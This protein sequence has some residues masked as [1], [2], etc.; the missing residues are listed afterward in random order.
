MGDPRTR[1]YLIPSRR[2]S[3]SLLYQMWKHTRSRAEP[4][5][6]GPPK[7]PLGARGDVFDFP[8]RSDVTL[9]CRGQAYP[10]PSFR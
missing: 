3:T 9:P 6:S 2:S 1:W 7:V 8:A 5:S 4:V 10:V